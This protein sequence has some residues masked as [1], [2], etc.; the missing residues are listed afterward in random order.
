MAEVNTGRQK[1]EPWLG[2]MPKKFNLNTY[3]FHVLRD[4]V[5]MIKSFGMTDSFTTQVVSISL[6][7]FHFTYVSISI[8]RAGAPPDQE[9]VWSVK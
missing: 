6:D 2:S 8:G 1:K 5:G 9:N 4:Y 7:Y 3:K